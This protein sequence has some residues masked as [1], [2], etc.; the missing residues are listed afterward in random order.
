MLLFAVLHLGIL[1]TLMRKL[2]MERALSKNTIMHRCFRGGCKLQRGRQSIEEERKEGRIKPCFLY[3]CCMHTYR[4]MSVSMYMD[5][6]AKKD[7]G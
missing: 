4:R 2:N 7:A 3:M 5:A 1:E 6:E